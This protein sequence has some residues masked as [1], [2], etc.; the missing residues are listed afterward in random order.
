[1]YGGD[2]CLYA[3]Y[4]SGEDSGEGRERVHITTTYRGE[5]TSFDNRS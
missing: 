2:V 4:T 3:E 1:M 5:C